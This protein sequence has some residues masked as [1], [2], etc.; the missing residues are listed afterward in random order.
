MVM[1]T[2]GQRWEVGLRSSYR[3]CWFWQKKIIFSDET[4][5]DLGGYVNKQNCRIWG[6]ENPHAY[7]EKPTY[8]KRV[9]VWCEVWFRGIIGQ[10]FFENKQEEDVTVNGNRYR[11]ILNEFLFLRYSRGGYWEH[12]VLTGRHSVP[13]S[14]SYTRCFEPCFWRSHYQPQSWCRLAI[15]ELWF[16]TVWL[17]FVGRCQR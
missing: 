7:T 15:S 4:H 13:H 3:R 14:Q 6:T 1:Y 11:I 10:F 9:T 2:L 8:P 5:F 16:E 17:L 12:L